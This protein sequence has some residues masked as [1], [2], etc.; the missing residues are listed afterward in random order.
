LTINVNKALQA[1]TCVLSSRS[2]DGSSCLD[3]LWQT[4]EDDE[5]GFNTAFAP[6]LSACLAHPETPIALPTFEDNFSGYTLAMNWLLET[7]GDS[8]VT[9]GWHMNITAPPEG[10][11]W[12]YNDLNSIQIMN[13]FTAPVLETLEATAYGDP[14]W[15]PDFLAFDKYGADDTQVGSGY[16]YFYNARD[17][18]NYLTAV[19]QTSIELGNLPIMLWQIPGGHIQYEGDPFA[20]AAHI[21]S[22]ATYLFGDA[23]LRTD[24]SNAINLSG[25]IHHCAPACDAIGYLRMHDYDWNASD[26]IAA[27]INANVFAIHWM[28]YTLPTVGIY[29]D[30]YG[31]LDDKGWLSNKVA[32]YA[33]AHK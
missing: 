31:P 2:F 24:L 28:C 6:V 9:Y 30:H 14:A 27:V 29:V 3:D 1:A 16:P 15:M 22:F 21:S 25:D 17:W 19:Q 12:I 23:N 26:K 5:S 4:Y 13:T 32:S 8:T 18:D 11:A 20:D 33:A 10:M 7:Y